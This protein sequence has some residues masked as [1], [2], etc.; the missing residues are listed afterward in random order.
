MV[1]AT[2]QVGRGRLAVVA[3]VCPR[4]GSADVR[5]LSLIHQAGLSVG[6]ESSPAR[7]L[8]RHAAPPTRKRAGVWVVL[9]VTSLVMEAATF[10]MG[11]P[12]AIAIAG[13]ALA[14][15]VFAVQAASYNATT[16]PRLL[17]LWE[18]SFMCDRCGELFSGA[19]D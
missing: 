7:A 9:L 4:C 6:D 8:S 14:A 15:S 19:Q 10:A 5:R 16:Y 11:G 13:V 18:R 12:G 2:Q 3:Q 17:A 1:I